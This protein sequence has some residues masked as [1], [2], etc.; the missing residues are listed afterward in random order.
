MGSFCCC[1]SREEFEEYTYSNGSLSRHCISLT[2]LLHQLLNG[3]AA[4]FRRIEGRSVSLSP[5]SATSLA[6]AGSDLNF[7]ESSS[8]SYHSSS[9]TVPYDAD[10]RYSCLPRDG[11]VLRREKSASRFNEELQPLR[12]GNNSAGVE[13]MSSMDKVNGLESEGHSM[14]C[15]SESAEKSLFVKAA[16]GIA[17][18][19]SSAE[20]EDVCPTCL[21][22]DGVQ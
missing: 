1:P 21:D 19:L 15:H 22:G 13:T 18:R 8:D 2:Y 11:L 5:H 9:R 12:R 17:Y 6:P 7:P 16:R 10:S 3:Y 20:D 4:V 14:S